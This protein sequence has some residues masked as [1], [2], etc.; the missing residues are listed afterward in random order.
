MFEGYITALI[1][2]FTADGKVDEKA[3]QQLIERQ[4]KAGISAI[5]ACGTTG[6]TPTLSDE[7]YEQVLTLAVKTAAGR[8]PVIG[9]AGTNNTKTTIECTQLVQKL[10]CKTALI[11]APYYNKP[12]QEGLYQHYKAVHDATNIPILLYNVPGRSVVDINVDTIAR[13]AKLPRIIGIKEC[14]GDVNRVVKTRAATS[15]QFCQ[16]TG[17]DGMI[18]PFLAQGG[19]GCVSVTSNIAPELCVDLYKAWKNKD[20]ATFMA[21]NDRLVPL[22]DA[23]FCETSPGPVKYASALMGL[24]LENLRLPLATP[25]AAASKTKVESALE[26]AGIKINKSNVQRTANV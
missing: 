8:I 6:E 11:A 23:M 18:A 10:G 19:V 13:L 24:C 3:Y 7:E 14:S 1:T 26:K 2:P 17:D 4:I 9:G 5:V 12:T 16:L 15:P 25:I 21:L 22:H 20:L